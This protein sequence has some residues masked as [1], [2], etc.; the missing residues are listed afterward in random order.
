MYHK[1]LHKSEVKRCC[2]ANERDP[3]ENTPQESI[4]ENQFK[5]CENEN[6]TEENNAELGERNAEEAR[7]LARGNNIAIRK[8]SDGTDER[9]IAQFMLSKIH[10]I[11]KPAEC[12]NQYAHD[13]SALHSV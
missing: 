1:N 6:N 8:I 5:S 13:P 11:S 10:R 9:R 7:I 3:L 12:E 4:E 2:D